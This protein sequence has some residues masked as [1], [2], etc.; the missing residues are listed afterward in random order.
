MEILDMDKWERR[1]AYG[2]FSKVSNPFYM[3]TFRQDITDLYDFVKK[4]G[5]SFYYGLIWACTRAINDTDAFLVSYRDGRLVRIPERSPS[6]T[7][8]RKDGEQ[9]YI[10]SAEPLHGI[11]EFCREAKR[12]SGSQTVFIDENRESDDLIYFSCL[13]WV[14]MT[15]LTNERD[16][17][18]PDF[19]HD[20]V[21]H[22][23]WG[24]YT[25]DGAGRKILGLSVE[26]NHR[27]IDGLHIGRFAERLTYYS[28][29]PEG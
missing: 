5:L 29:N 27:Y 13:P 10:V 23:A 15:A 22:I 3:V 17:S 26:V 18:S 19:A 20:S 21:P 4:N 12:L 14:D 7:D 24:K 11:R 6:F 25:E 28:S 9:F 16:S 1:E 8:I 2:F